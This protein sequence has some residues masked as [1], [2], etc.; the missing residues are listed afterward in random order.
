M[1]TEC[2]DTPRGSTASAPMTF[3]GRQHPILS[4]STDPAALCAVSECFLLARAGVISV[5]NPPILVKVNASSS[6][7]RFHTFL[8]IRRSTPSCPTFISLTFRRAI[9]E[10][11]RCR[12]FPVD[13]RV[14]RRHEVLVLPLA[15]FAP[16]LTM[17]GWTLIGLLPWLLAPYT[18]LHPFHQYSD[19]KCGSAGQ[20][21]RG[22]RL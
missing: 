12:P 6:D 13:P 14:A 15:P 18:S 10:Y 4:V 20:S 16:E 5:P 17:I 1:S 19:V 8:V 3:H 22:F 7:G 9:C 21:H 2:A 11:T